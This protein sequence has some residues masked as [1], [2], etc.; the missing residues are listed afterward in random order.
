MCMFWS[1]EQTG[2][3]TFHLHGRFDTRTFQH[4]G[5]LAQGIF[6]AMDVS[7]RDILASKC[8]G[9][10]IFW[11]LAKQFGHFLHRHFGTCATVPKCP[12]AEMSPHQNVH[13]AKK[14][15]CRKVSVPKS[16][17][18]ETSTEMKCPCAKTNTGPQPACAE[19]SW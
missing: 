16:P 1:C 12:C 19:M 13:G 11:H 5:I 18:N 2:T 15:L 14:F 7:A 8:F 10:L 3:W 17:C 4:G 9:T 6:G